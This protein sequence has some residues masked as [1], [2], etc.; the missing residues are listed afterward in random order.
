MSKLAVLSSLKVAN[1]GLHGSWPMFWRPVTSVDLS[2]NRISDLKALPATDIALLRDIRQLHIKDGLLAQAL[3][4]GLVL[5]LF[6]TE[7]ET[8]SLDLFGVVSLPID[9]TASVSIMYTDYLEKPVSN[10]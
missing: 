2:G 8:R 4:T 3:R 1:A 7:L 10:T 9:V 5:D 6:E